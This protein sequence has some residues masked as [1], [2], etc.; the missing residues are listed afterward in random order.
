[1]PSS[2]VGT[3][4]MQVPALCS[5]SGQTQTEGKGAQPLLE[6]MYPVEGKA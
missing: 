3:G 6:T 1:M 2:T 4:H 5:G